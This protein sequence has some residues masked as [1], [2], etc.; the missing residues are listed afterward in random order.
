MARAL[1]AEMVAAIN[2]GSVYPVFFY[3]GEFDGGTL[4]L[5]TGIGEVSW[6]S[7]TWTGAGNMLAISPIQE[8]TDNKAIGFSA[9][10]SG[11]LSSI[12]AIALANVRQGLQEAC[13]LLRTTRALRSCW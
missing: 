11:Q 9:S 4:N 1:T 5:W 6:D 10:L 3:E 8:S 12:L 2:A 7:K 13:G